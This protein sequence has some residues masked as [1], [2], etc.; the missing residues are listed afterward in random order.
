MYQ[1]CNSKCL[2]LCILLANAFSLCIFTVTKIYAILVISRFLTGFFQVFISIYY[3]VWADRFGTSEKQKATW[4]SV[5]LF[6]STFGVLVGYIV[7][8]QM[9]QKVSWQW[10]FYI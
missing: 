3:P 9:V 10:A 8:A 6:S 2:L 7:T 1:Q 5:L 4:M